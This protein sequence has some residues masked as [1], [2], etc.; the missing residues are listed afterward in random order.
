[1]IDAD[2]QFRSTL[3]LSALVAVTAACVAPT[4]TESAHQ[5]KAANTAP[6][7]GEARATCCPR[8]AGLSLTERSISCRHE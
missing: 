1:L 5:T 7:A 6:P 4:R 2:E 8:S 3:Q